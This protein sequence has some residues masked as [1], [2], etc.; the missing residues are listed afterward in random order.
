MADARRPLVI[1]VIALGT[2][3]VLASP[4]VA[5]GWTPLDTELDP[6]V[7]MPGSQPADGIALAAPDQCLNCHDGYDPAVDIGFHWRGGMMAQAGRDPFFWASVAVAAQDSIWAIGRPNATD[8]CLRCHSPAGWLGGRSDPTNGSALTGSDLDGV[9]CDACHRLYDP[10]F[11]DT[12]AGTREGDDWDG[13]WDEG[14]GVP[15]VAAASTR[16]ADQ[17]ESTRA[18]F[19]NGSAWFDAAW[20]PVAGAWGENGGGQ[21]FVAVVEDERASMADAVARHPFFYSRYH[22]S[23][24]VCGTCHDVSNPVL[25]NLAHAGTA[26]GDGTTVLP[27]EAQATYAYFH[28]ERTFSELMLSAYGTGGGAPG[29]GAFAPSVFE[30]SRPGNVIATCQDCHMPDRIGAGCD[31][32]DAI[33]R[34][35][36]TAHPNSGQ[37]LHDLTGGNVIVPWLLASTVPGS[38]NHDVTNASLLGAGPATLTMDLTAGLGLDAPALL[39]A[40]GRALLT[41]Q[42]AAAI[43]GL[44]YDAD[45]GALTFH[46]RNDSGHKLPTGYP[47]GRRAFVN[48]QVWQA[49][50]IV[51]E[52]NPYDPAAGT[53]KGLPG[54]AP[55]GASE[56]ARDDLVY[57]A[58]LGSSLTGETHTFHFALSDGRQKDNRI[59]PRGFRIAEATAR[60]A[61]PVVAGVS[62]PD[63]YT[64]AEYAG[65]HD[66]VTLTVPAGADGIV[67]ALYYQSTSR[68]FVEFLR[69]EINGTATSLSSPT[70]SGEASAY[71]A[72]TDPFFAGLVAWGDTIWQ[73]WQHNQSAPG[74]APILVAHDSV[75]AVGDPCLEPSSDG[76]PCSDGDPCTVGDT[77]GGGVCV[78]GEAV[79][80]LDAGPPDAV[81]TDASGQPDAARGSDGGGDNGGDGGAPV[82]AGDGSGCDCQTGPSGRTGGGALLGLALVA[83]VMLPRRMGTGSG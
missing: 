20:Q 39:A 13:Y 57:E 2:V 48:V 40:S 61:E 69:D 5:L 83:L 17:A 65:G 4:R 27:S 1:L 59:P 47:E 31:K 70:S 24:Y 50:A 12:F 63:L 28:A 41:P 34:P 73:L 51:H 25:A 80:C 14:D 55:L 22:K 53:L 46:V 45:S 33:V 30:T 6:L 23:R 67:V 56:A 43:D 62:A 7:R 54:A 52:V 64:A 72:G 26:P 60:L 21:L 18:R 32:P 8:I 75:G 66:D 36:G 19:F 77:C 71:V 76:A 35:G 15:A 58:R 49:G 82:D 10:F 11:E 74:I 9:T 16:L 44:A 38:P 42:S 78:P 81:P 3:A 79:D 68:E 37:P 29:G